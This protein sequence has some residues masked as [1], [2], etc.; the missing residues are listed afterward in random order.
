MSDIYKLQYNS[1]TLIFPGWNG[2]VSYES[3]P[4]AKTLTLCA[5]EGGTLTATSITGYPGDTVTLSTAYNTYWRFS[6]YKVQGDGT[7]SNNTYT[8]GE[9]DAQSVSAYYKKNA[10]TA[11]GTFALAST[12]TASGGSTGSTKTVTANGVLKAFTGSKPSNW[13]ATNATWNVSNASSYHATASFSYT[14]TG[15]VSSTCTATMYMN[16][17]QQSNNA[18]TAKASTKITA[19]TTASN[20]TQQGTMKASFTLH[21][22]NHGAYYTHTTATLYTQGF[23]A[24]GYAP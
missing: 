15:S 19:G 21:G 11:T 22:Y 14:V 3:A 23:T 6:G 8:F 2:A 12:V 5:S 4:P 7:L 16:G 9:D 1:M 18:Y 20:K 24:T 10:F 13:P 17:A